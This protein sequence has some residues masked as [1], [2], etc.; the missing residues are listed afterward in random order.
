MSGAIER[1][2]LVSLREYVSSSLPRGGHQTRGWLGPATCLRNVAG[3]L[4]KPAR[5]IRM[6]NCFRCEDCGWVCE[7][8]PDR[9]WQGAYAREC[10]WRA[11]PDPQSRRGP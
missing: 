5:I 6:T 2:S 8:H 11:L 7:N 4:S 10:G 9:P 3:P 1:V